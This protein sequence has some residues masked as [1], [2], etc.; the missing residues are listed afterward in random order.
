MTSASA[1]RTSR[2]RVST[3][4]LGTA[5]TTHINGRPIAE[6]STFVPVDRDDDQS[7]G[8]ENAI[9]QDHPTYGAIHADFKAYNALGLSKILLIENLAGAQCQLD[10]IYRRDPAETIRKSVEPLEIHMG[11]RPLIRGSNAVGLEV[12]NPDD[13]LDMIQYMADSVDAKNRPMV[14]KGFEALNRPGHLL[15]LLKV[16]TNLRKQGYKIEFEA[17]YSYTNDCANDLEY[18]DPVDGRRKNLDPLAPDFVQGVVHDE[19]AAENWVYEMF[20]LIANPEN[21]L[22]PELAKSAFG[23]KDFIGGLVGNKGK[24]EDGNS[25]LLTEAMWRGYNRFL[26]EYLKSHP[27][28][29]DDP[30]FAPTICGH[31]HNTGF[32]PEAVAAAIAKT[33]ELIKAAAPSSP[34]SRAK[35]RSDIIY[36]GTTFSSVPAA[37]EELKKT[38]GYDSGVTEGQIAMHQ[39][40]G[41]MLQDLKKFYSYW[42]NKTDSLA[43][44]IS[45]AVR[46]FALQAG[47]AVGSDERMGMAPLVPILMAGLEQQGIK[48]S[49]EDAGYMVVALFTRTRRQ[50][51]FDYAHAQNVTPS[52]KNISAS[53]RYII[54]GMIKDGFVKA[55]LNG[56]DTLPAVDLVAMGKSKEPTPM[57]KKWLCQFSGFYKYNRD[58]LALEYYRSTPRPIH[59]VLMKVSCDFHLNAIFP[60][61]KTI[62]DK[63]KVNVSSL[64][65]TEFAERPLGR[66]LTPENYEQVKARLLELSDK[67]EEARAYLEGFISD[68]AAV[69]LFVR[70]HIGAD[71]MPPDYGKPR[72][73]GIVRDAIEEA[74]AKGVMHISEAGALMSGL[75]F[76]INELGRTAYDK[77]ADYTQRLWKKPVSVDPL[78]GAE[79]GDFIDLAL[80][81]ARQLATYS[82]IMA[83]KAAI[84]LRDL[85]LQARQA[86]QIAAVQKAI[87]GG[88]PIG[89]LLAEGCLTTLREANF[90]DASSQIRVARKLEKA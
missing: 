39:K 66:F 49:K 6:I 12:L 30:A 78:F 69:D 62:A 9:P 7:N 11:V 18:V 3:E 21:E 20:Q 46:R 76:G 54:E 68:K 75:M 13:L 70:Q 34:M 84:A 8:G 50:L 32:A 26:G 81:T 56:T 43:S 89:E 19:K 77:M 59:P 61:L 57:P 5:P 22:D 80:L 51:T 73:G 28:L 23:F 44:K 64:T 45:N 65:P 4:L 71:E 31:T 29:A 40:W 87:D 33:L 14:I 36:D 60:D 53:A 83:E 48:V 47:G 25:Y 88:L 15:P 41:G 35:I 38:W 82:G 37:H 72:I 74:K 67:K 85:T 17:A 42:L 79:K 27:E 2:A 10:A 63:A 24:V 16:I 1:L 86:A 90:P 55:M 52:A 58:R